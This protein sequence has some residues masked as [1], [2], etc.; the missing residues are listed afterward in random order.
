[1]LFSDKLKQLR[2]KKQLLQRQ[3]SAYLEIDNALYCKIERGERSAKREQVIFLAKLF[4]VEEKELLKLWMADKVY[5]LA[6]EE[7]NLEDIL[8]VVAENIVEYKKIKL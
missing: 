7:D 4:N 6:G 1:M 3:V 2:E 8:T 5:S